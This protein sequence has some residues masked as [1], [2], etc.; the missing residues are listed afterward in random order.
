MK[1]G[2]HIADIPDNDPYFEE[3]EVN[4]F[5]RCDFCGC[6]VN[7]FEINW[8]TFNGKNSGVCY[9]DDCKPEYN[10]WKSEPE[11]QDDPLFNFGTFINK[12]F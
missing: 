12:L 4:H 3:K 8:D 11:N 5:K 2:N 9:C 10:K 6:M 7:E 1:T